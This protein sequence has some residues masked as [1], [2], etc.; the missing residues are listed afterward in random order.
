MSEALSGPHLGVLV[1]TLLYLVLV[2]IS[3]VRALRLPSRSV[4]VRLL[5]S[6][7]IVAVPVGGLVVFWSAHWPNRRPVAS[8]L[9]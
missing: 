7:A 8:S 5:W 9:R 4:T 1:A 2:V 6:I 3:V